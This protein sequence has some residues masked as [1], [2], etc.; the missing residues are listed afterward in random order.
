[1]KNLFSRIFGNQSKSIPEIVGKKLEL[2]FPNALNIEWEK[3]GEMYE[4]VFYV[5]DVEHIALISKTGS[6][7]EYKKN[8][9]LEELPEVVKT[10]GN[11]LGEI[12]NVILI[13]HGEEVFYELIIRNHKLD[14][15]EYL[16][17]NTGVALRTKKL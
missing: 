2:T 1:M 5:D 15:F 17:D 14:R 10:G 6:L 4:A 7:I 13:Y 11:A 3:K 16:F 9:W 8:I 12:M